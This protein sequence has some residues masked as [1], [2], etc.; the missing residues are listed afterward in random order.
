[1]V[2]VEKQISPLRAARFGRNDDFGGAIGSLGVLGDE[3]D[4]AEE[5]GGDGLDFVEVLHLEA[6][7]VFFYE[8]FVVVRREGG[9]GV[10]GGVVDVDLDV[11]LAGLEEF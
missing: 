4:G 10:E 1:M 7:A 8:G 6:V 11:V 9:P 3:V 5:A 2:W